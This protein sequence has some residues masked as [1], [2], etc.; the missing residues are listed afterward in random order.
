M[1]N[2]IPK[3]WSNSPRSHFATQL[4]LTKYIS[5]PDELGGFTPATFVAGV[6]QGFLDGAG[7]STQYPP[8]FE[9][10]FCLYIYCLFVR[11]HR[12]VVRLV[13]RLYSFS[14]P[15]LSVTRRFS[16]SR[17]GPPRDRTWTNTSAHDYSDSLR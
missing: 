5:V 7:T 1:Y 14:S 3:I 2:I 11:G 4:C 9:L 17:F 8:E 6:V 12:V 13:L 10:D 15:V 16:G